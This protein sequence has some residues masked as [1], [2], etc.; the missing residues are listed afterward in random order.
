MLKIKVK[1]EMSSV[2]NLDTTAALNV[3]I[4]SDRNNIPSITNLATNTVLTS[5]EKNPN[6]KNFK[7]KLPITQK[8]VKLKI[9]LPLIMLDNYYSRI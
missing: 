3:K 9:E 7:K 5:V 8:L 1:L 2:I 6:V 4:N